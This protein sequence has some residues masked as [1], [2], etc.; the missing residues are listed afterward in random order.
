MFASIASF[1]FSLNV[2]SAASV[3]W[4][5]GWRVCVCLHVCV[6]AHVRVKE[7]RW[8]KEREERQQEGGEVVEVEA[9]G[10]VGRWNEVVV[11]HTNLQ[12]RADTFVR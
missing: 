2:C 6:L 5:A 8:R 12:R 7:A 3:G 10:G 4:L 1:Q 9:R 11:R